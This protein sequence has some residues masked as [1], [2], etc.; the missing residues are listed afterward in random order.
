MESAFGISLVPMFY[1]RLRTVSLSSRSL[2]F[3]GSQW[4]SSAEIGKEVD[5]EERNREYEKL[6]LTI[7]GLFPQ[8]TGRQKAK[9]VL[10]T[11]E[12]SSF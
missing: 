7:E 1:L 3:I 6:F 4:A 5:K 10:R 8:G 11:A 12:Q 9:E 2:S